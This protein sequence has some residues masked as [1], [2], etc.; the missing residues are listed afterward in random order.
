MCSNNCFFFVPFFSP[1]SVDV[2][3]ATV[4]SITIHWLV[5]VLFKCWLIA[6]VTLLLVYGKKVDF[7]VVIWHDF[8]FCRQLWM[9]CYVCY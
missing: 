2:E 1:V 6:A 9:R 5:I 7:I 4:S 8:L 3:D